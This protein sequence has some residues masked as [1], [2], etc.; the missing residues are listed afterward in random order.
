MAH[1]LRLQV[2]VEGVETDQQFKFLQKQGCDYVQGY[3]VL[4]LLLLPELYEF[5]KTWKQ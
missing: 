5:L 1:D 4:K 3:Y 2:I